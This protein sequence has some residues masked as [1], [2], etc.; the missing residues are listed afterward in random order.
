ME[1]TINNLKAKAALLEGFGDVIETL[2]KNV[3]YYQHEDPE[4]G[5][6]VDDDDTWSAGRVR[7]Y[8]EA[9]EA[10]KKLAGVK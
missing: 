8:R 9:I 1:E 6:M 5:K 10:V 4:T 3:R 7:A 2:Y